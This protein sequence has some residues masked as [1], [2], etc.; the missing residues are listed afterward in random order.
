MLFPSGILTSLKIQDFIWYIISQ[1]QRFLINTSSD[2]GVLNQSLWF[3]R[4]V[5]EKAYISSSS[6]DDEEDEE[7]DEDDSVLAEPLV[8]I[9]VFLIE[10]PRQV[11]N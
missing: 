8:H 2:A 5:S 3:K 11:N 1:S 7:D 9:T 10:F 6:S 4:V